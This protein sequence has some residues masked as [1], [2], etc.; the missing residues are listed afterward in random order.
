[1]SIS[2]FQQAFDTTLVKMWFWNMASF[3]IVSVWPEIQTCTNDVLMKATWCTVNLTI[4]RT[5]TL[6]IMVSN[7]NAS[8]RSYIIPNTYRAVHSVLDKHLLIVLHKSLLAKMFSWAGS[9]SR[10]IVYAA[11]GNTLRISLQFEN[12]CY[13][14]GYV[15]FTKLGH[16]Q[17]YS[18][19]ST[20]NLCQR[21][22]I[23]HEMCVLDLN[24]TSYSEGIRQCDS[25]NTGELDLHAQHQ[26][27]CLAS[28]TPRVVVRQEQ[29]VLSGTHW[30]S[31][32]HCQMSVVLCL[33]RFPMK[34][35]NC[36]IWHQ[37]PP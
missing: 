4:K 28:R 20:Q 37:R 2:W 22:L 5:H 23:I 17:R 32:A 13:K 15:C 14:F 24:R 35:E 18:S 12:L 21:Q 19:L 9:S 26:Q 31:F 10:S 1:M 11:G 8:S 6:V 33:K 3:L 25:C 29:P 30:S 7:E 16:M 34:I 27:H 36:H